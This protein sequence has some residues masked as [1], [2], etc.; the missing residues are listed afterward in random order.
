MGNSDGAATGCDFIGDTHLVLP[1]LVGVEVSALIFVCLRHGCGT[2]H[3]LPRASGRT[4]ISS[5]D[6]S[7]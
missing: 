5:Y 6:P 3:T 7:G 1:R 2:R 4:G